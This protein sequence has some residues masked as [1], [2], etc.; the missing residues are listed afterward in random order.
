VYLPKRA[1]QTYLRPRGWTIPLN[2]VFTLNLDQGSR[3]LFI[4]FLGFIRAHI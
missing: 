4:G 1:P 3:D 2:S